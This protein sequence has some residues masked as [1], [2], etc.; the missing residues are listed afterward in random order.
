M[1]T[2]WKYVVEPENEQIIGMPCGAQP[3]HAAMQ[4]GEIC[5]WMFVRHNNPLVPR[6]VQ[7]RGTGRNEDGVDPK[8]HVGSVLMRDGYL[9]LHIFLK[10]EGGG[11]RGEV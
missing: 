8:D 4:H 3:L 1:R 2:I 7:V 11:K 9:V 10:K 6:V 5:L